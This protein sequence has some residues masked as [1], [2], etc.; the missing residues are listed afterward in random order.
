MASQLAGRSIF[1]FSILLFLFVYA[2]TVLSFKKEHCID[3]S[4]HLWEPNNEYS[5][6]RNP[7]L[8]KMIASTKKLTAVLCGEQWF[9]TIQDNTSLS[10]LKNN[11]N[12]LNDLARE[13]TNLHSS[14]LVP[15]NS[16]V[17]DAKARLLYYSSF[18]KNLLDTKITLLFLHTYIQ[19]WMIVARK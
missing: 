19:G 6:F 2:T 8:A 14:L 1:V 4:Y 9:G 15:Q 17:D 11:G 7:N 12:L 13:L 18:F 10:S 16:C 5:R 3:L